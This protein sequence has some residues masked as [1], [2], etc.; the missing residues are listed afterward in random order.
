MSELEF[1]LLGPLEVLRAGRPVEVRAAKQRVV[2]AALLW[3][4]GQSVPLDE[5]T[6][7]LWGEDP[8]GDARGTLRAY[9]M[10]L[11]HA[12]GPDQNLIATR[13]DGYLLRLDHDRLDLHRFDELLAGADRAA[14]AGDPDAE[15]VAVSQALAL[16]RGP[17]LSNVPSASLRRDAAPALAERRLAALERR[18]DLDLGLDPGSSASGAAR[19]VAELRRLT[20]E[21]PLRE[22]FWAQLMRALHRSG[23]QAE[24]LDAFQR[25]REV[26][27]EELG[28]DPGA[29][30]RELHVALLR[31]EAIGPAP[32]K[33]AG[34]GPAPPGPPHPLELPAD[35]P[36]FVGRAAPL[37]ELATL[38]G[39]RAAPAPSGEGSPRV[40]PT[41]STSRA[42]SRS[43]PSTGWKRAGANT[44]GVTAVCREPPRPARPAAEPL[45]GWWWSP[46][47]RASARPR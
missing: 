9:V 6:E 7:R 45:R 5:L 25:V 39:H 34:P 21:H 40:V 32:R 3:R 24:A 18:I 14:A 17:A 16:W 47:R 28:V 15:R 12:L 11:R 37:A 19:L 20:A 10:R 2:L 46:A 29:E 41:P 13:P 27:R 8:P 30:L 36:D 26:L 43:A 31:G 4:G 38:L 23:R 33:A 22:R 1:R 35:L 44:S 42:S